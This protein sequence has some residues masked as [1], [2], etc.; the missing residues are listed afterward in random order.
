M[1]ALLRLYVML[2]IGFMLLNWLIDGII[3]ILVGEIE[4]DEE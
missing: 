2:C 4:E 1:L 3:Y